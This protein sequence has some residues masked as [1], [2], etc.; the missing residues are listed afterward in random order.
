[1]G[2]TGTRTT[3]TGPA[4]VDRLPG[5]CKQRRAHLAKPTFA[6]RSDDPLFDEV[7]DIGRRFE[8]ALL[9]DSPLSPL[10]RQYVV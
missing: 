7:R 6:T 4:T 3:A 8:R 5:H 9:F 10:V 1:M 2:R